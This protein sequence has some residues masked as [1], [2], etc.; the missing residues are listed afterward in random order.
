MCSFLYRNK[1][2]KIKKKKNDNFFFRVWNYKKHKYL[3]YF[4]LFIIVIVLLG[5]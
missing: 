3:N 1:I 4:S 5:I 2:G